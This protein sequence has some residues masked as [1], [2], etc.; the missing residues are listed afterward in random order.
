MAFCLGSTRL[1][2]AFA[3][4]SFASWE[5]RGV[6]TLRCSERGRAGLCSSAGGSSASAKDGDTMEGMPTLQRPQEAPKQTEPKLSKPDKRLT[7]AHRSCVV[8]SKLCKWCGVRLPL[9]GGVTTTGNAA[10]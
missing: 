6:W 4:A 5:S 3:F 10:D 2:F 8:D 7:A 9:W 1:A